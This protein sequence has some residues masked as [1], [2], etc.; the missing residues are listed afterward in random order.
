MILNL[1]QFFG[2]KEWELFITGNVRGGLSLDEEK[3]NY[4]EKCGN[5][6]TEGAEFCENCGANV[7]KYET[8]DTEKFIHSLEDYIG[9]NPD[10]YFKKWKLGSDGHPSKKI[11]W[12]WVAFFFPYFWAGYRKMYSTLLLIYGLFLG[13]DIIMLLTNTDSLQ[14]NTNIGLVVGVVLAL[15]GNQLYF[16]KAKKQ[17]IN[18]E[19][20]DS[21]TKK[22][23]LQKAGGTSKLGILYSVLLFILYLLISVFIV[24][25]IFGNPEEIEF[26]KDSSDGYI[27]ETTDQFEPAE[28]MHVHFNFADGEGG[29]Y[30]IVLE[31]EEDDSTYVYDEWED[32]APADWPGAIEVWNVPAEEGNYTVK[33]IEDDEISTQGTFTVEE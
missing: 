11:S 30:E 20:M 5:G 2:T 15:N 10:Y 21:E 24:D 14:M 29:A 26:G 17:I 1:M 19:E 31:K 4:C 27:E 28:E 13:L 3:N 22:E 9:K 25:P 18:R 23:E 6:L 16:D 12:N 32:E 33:V 8:E 7:N